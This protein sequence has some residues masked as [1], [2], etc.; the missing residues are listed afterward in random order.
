MKDLVEAGWT[1]C[2]LGVSGRVWCWGNNAQSLV[3]NPMVKE[4]VYGPDEVAVEPLPILNPSW[5]NKNARLFNSHGNVC[6]LKEVGSLWCAG[7]NQYGEVNPRR[8]GD[9][10]PTRMPV[11]CP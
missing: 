9:Q 11:K 7:R 10:P 3:A 2:A 6:S 4:H 1:M 5:G 8:Q